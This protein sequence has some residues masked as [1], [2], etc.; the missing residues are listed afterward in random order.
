MDCRIASSSVRVDVCGG[1]GAMCA[2]CVNTRRAVSARAHAAARCGR[3]PFR[4]PPVQRARLHLHC[5]RLLV[6]SSPLPGSVRGGV[7]GGSDSGVRSG[8][9][10]SLDAGAA[11]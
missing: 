4:Q 9:R 2:R 8:L 7:R 10:H 5:A 11:R 6:R 3:E 1:R